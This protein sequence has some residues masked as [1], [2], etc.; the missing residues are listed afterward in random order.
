MAINVLGFATPTERGTEGY[1]KAVVTAVETI[2]PWITLLPLVSSVATGGESMNT[3]LK[4][5]LWKWLDKQREDFKCNQP[6]IK[7]WCAVHRSNWHGVI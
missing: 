2:L 3:G 7:M 4:K 6:L 1:T 5:S